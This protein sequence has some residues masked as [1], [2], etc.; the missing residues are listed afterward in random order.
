[1]DEF[2]W[3]LPVSL[4]WFTA[5]VG[6]FWRLVGMIQRVEK[7]LAASASELHD[8]VNRVREDMVKKADLDGHLNRMSDDMREMRN[9]QS[10]AAKEQ[11]DANQ[12]TNKRL[13][14]LMDA[15]TSGRK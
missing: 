13:D 6:A 14:E 1:M 5:L 12:A 8:R 11:R 9:N 15:I 4:A 3:I 7:D 10:D 2:G